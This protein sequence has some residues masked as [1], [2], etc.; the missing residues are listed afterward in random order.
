M[1]KEKNRFCILLGFLMHVTRVNKELWEVFL[2]VQDA[3]S[4]HRFNI[5]NQMSICIRFNKI[6][7]GYFFHELLSQLLNKLHSNS[8]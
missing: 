1:M 7:W 5:F 8:Y 4:T 2:K 3:S 6:K